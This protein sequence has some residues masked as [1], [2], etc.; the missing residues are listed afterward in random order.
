MIVSIETPVAKGAFLHSCVRSVLAQT[1]DRW[2]FSLWWDGGDE[3]SRR[4]L[5]EIEALDH[6]SITVRFGEQRGIA[7]A[8][9][10]LTESSCGE[11]ILPLDDDD[12]LAPDAVA[13]FLDAAGRAPWAGVVR[14]RRVFIDEGGQRVDEADWFPFAPRRYYSGMTVDLLNHAQPTLIARHAYDRTSGWEGFPDYGGA[15]EDC[16]MV[17][18]IEEVADVVLLDRCLYHY[19]LHPGRASHALGEPAAVDMWR[20]IADATAR[21]RGLSL[22]RVNARQPFNYARLRRAALDG[23]AV[24]CATVRSGAEAAAALNDADGAALCLV[25]SGMDGSEAQVLAGLLEALQ[26]TDADVAAA[27][28]AD[29]KE[30]PLPRPL[31][32]S[33][34]S[35]GPGKPLEGM[36]DQRVPGCRAVL[37]RREVWRS[38]A[39]PDAALRSAAAVLADL[40]VRARL[41]GFDCRVLPFP[42]AGGNADGVPVEDRDRLVRRWRSLQVPLRAGAHGANAPRRSAVASAPEAGR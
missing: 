32:H 1:D 7:G 14:A 35:A 38:M 34:S 36:D 17:A 12:C 20:R 3:S 13:G 27:F 5:A 21:R 29:A 15:G 18:K 41:R 19:R 6:P 25:D 33:P 26:A 8:R 9:R 22:Q 23:A 28:A 40:V 16:D 31:P 37:L 42:V 11:Y 30:R 24:A 10:A 2:R 39:G 4:I